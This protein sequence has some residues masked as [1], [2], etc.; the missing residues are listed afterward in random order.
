MNHKAFGTSFLYWVDFTKSYW[1]GPRVVSGLLTHDSDFELPEI[2]SYC[3]VLFFRY[4]FVTKSY[5]CGPGVG[6]GL[7]THDSDIEL[8]EI[9]G[10]RNIEKEPNNLPLGVSVQHLHKVYPN[11]KVA[12]EDLNLNFYEGQ[13]TSFLGHN[14]AGKTTTM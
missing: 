11:G 1:C 6:S 13:I 3:F 7:L 10:S 12:I 4:F 9:N 8:P 2:T 14:G 5:W